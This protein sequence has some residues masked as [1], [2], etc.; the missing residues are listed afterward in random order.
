MPQED[1]EGRKRYRTGLSVL[2]KTS[3]PESQEGHHGSPSLNRH[4]PL[5]AVLASASSNT[6]TVGE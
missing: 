3:D 5:E 6:V 1:G 2:S 4:F